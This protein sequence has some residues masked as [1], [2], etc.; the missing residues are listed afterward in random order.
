MSSEQNLQGKRSSTSAG[1]WPTTWNPDEKL[2]TP[3]G[4]HAEHFENATF[5]VGASPIS[6]NRDS[7]VSVGE[8]EE[9]HTTGFQAT[10]TSQTREMRGSEMT[11]QEV[12]EHERKIS[13]LRERVGLPEDPHILPEHESTT[14][15]SWPS[16]RVIFR[17][18]FAEFFGTM[19]MV[20]FGNG[21][22]AQV[23][24]GGG[25]I[26][27]PGGSGYGGYQSINWGWGI[28][29]FLGIYIAGDSGGYLNPAITM[30]FCLFRK[31]PWRRWPI[32]FL[33]QFL[34]GFV[35][36]GIVYANNVNGID[37]YEGQGIRTVPPLPS[38]TAAIFCTYPQTFLTK[39]SQF[40]SEFVASSI[41]M[42]VIFA[43]KDDSNP[44]AMGKSGAGPLFP[45]ALFF[46]IFGLGAAFGYVN[47]HREAATSGL[48]S[49]AGIRDT[50]STL[51]ATL[52]PVL[53]HI[54]LDMVRRSGLLV[55]TTSGFLW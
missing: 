31:L 1:S 43:L 35:G 37:K 32:Y 8:D 39:T 2:R 21:S 44:G 55:A 41:L 54:F 48:Y 47:T 19:V 15:F 46:L 36:A 42:F 17:E 29:I 26:S 28:G 20:M 7:E 4:G 27:A 14:S 30:G 13:H 49:L 23:L 53:C 38:A 3:T 5:E 18:P 16:F 40:V 51:L 52:A 6:K 50:L 45:L 9:G 24:L 22:V 34:G 25:E 12:Q 33:A 11:E 10:S